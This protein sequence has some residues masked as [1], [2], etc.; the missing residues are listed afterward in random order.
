[1]WKHSCGTFLWQICTQFEVY[2]ARKLAICWKTNKFRKDLNLFLAKKLANYCVYD[3]ENTLKSP[4][5]LLSLTSQRVLGKHYMNE[6]MNIRARSILLIK[7]WVEELFGQYHLSDVYCNKVCGF[8]FSNFIQ[9]PVS[10]RKISSPT[11]RSSSRFWQASTLN[12]CRMDA[13]TTFSSIIAKRWPG[14]QDDVI[15]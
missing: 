13:K 6:S 11:G 4:M 15:Y 3:D 2:R 14:E 5:S 8:L 10:G 9:I 12:L 7:I 1:M